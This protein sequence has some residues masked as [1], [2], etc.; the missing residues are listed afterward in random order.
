MVDVNHDADLFI[1][2]GQYIQNRKMVNNVQIH[3]ER[4][5]ELCQNSILKGKWTKSEDMQLKD[6][7][8]QY[9]TDNWTSIAAYFSNRTEVQCQQRW[10]K[11]LD[12]ALI[13]GAWTKEEDQL[14]IRLVHKYGPKKWSLIASHLKGRIG[15]QCR[16]RWH[17]HLNPDV[18][19]MA[20]SNEEDKLIYDLHCKLGN[21]WADIA[22]LLPGRTDNAIK[23]HWNSTMKRRY[24]PGYKEKSKPRANNRKRETNRYY[25][26]SDKTS[27]KPLS[28]IHPQMDSHYGIISSRDPMN[29]IAEESGEE[30]DDD[31]NIQE[32]TDSDLIIS[33]F[34]NM[35]NF[36]ELLADMGG[37]EALLQNDSPLH[38]N[39]EN[40]NKRNTN[41]RNFD[42][43]PPTM[44]SPPNILRRNHR[45][46]ALFDNNTSVNKDLRPVKELG[47][48]PS[49]FLNMSAKT[50]KVY[51]NEN[52]ALFTSTPAKIDPVRNKEKQPRK[53]KCID[54]IS[55]YDD[56][57]P[58]QN[59]VS[60]TPR[61][62]TP[63]KG[64]NKKALPSSTILKNPSIDEISE[65][66]QQ[67]SASTLSTPDHDYAKY[68]PEIQKEQLEQ[69]EVE[70]QQQQSEY[71]KDGLR[72]TLF[73]T[74][75]QLQLKT[76]GVNLFSEKELNAIE[77]M[78]SC[79]TP[80]KYSNAPNFIQ[81]F[82]DNEQF[83]RLTNQVR[84]E[85]SSTQR[86]QIRILPLVGKPMKLPIRKLPSSTSRNRK[87]SSF[88][89]LP[90][91]FKTVAYGQTNDQKFLTEQAK[92]IMKEI[93][94]AN[95]KY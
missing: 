91:D 95:I 45:K 13:K 60:T 87:Q 72:R 41:Y 92:L 49:V 28:E 76:C 74:P 10:N 17:N 25:E 62:P 39:K 69:E 26:Q 94:Q 50:E 43:M 32:T 65:L 51:N 35:S 31:I 84:N 82:Q 21:R 29:N 64:E 68:I 88:I 3:G 38:I 8:L 19:K 79:F 70:K 63:L 42:H 85:F 11:V 37:I 48:S 7:C 2:I 27:K 77:Q 20:W 75:S 55:T 71:G 58:K 56:L 89:A 15:K 18:N 46:K 57:H 53:R 86:K 14:V 52:N 44:V 5:D 54:T 9:G 33:P 34:R 93:G 4:I 36:S 90:N 61:T 12:P 59:M 40:F 6:Y 22:K 23:N 16:E 1:N 73:E 81:N 66:L 67:K 47:F 83:K 80:R 78:S 24:Q 30:V